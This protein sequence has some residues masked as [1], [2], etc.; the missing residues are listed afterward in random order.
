M[1]IYLVK[2]FIGFEG[3]VLEVRC[4]SLERNNKVFSMSSS[5]L[6]SVKVLKDAVDLQVYFLLFYFGEVLCQAS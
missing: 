3:R 5:G 4:K 2:V 6:Y 1:E